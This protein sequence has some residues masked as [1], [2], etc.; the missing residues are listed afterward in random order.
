M[1]GKEKRLLWLRP[2]SIRNYYEL[3]KKNSSITFGMMELNFYHQIRNLLIGF[4]LLELSEVLDSANHLRSVRVFVVVPSNNL[5]ERV[6]VTHL[7]NHSLV[8]IEE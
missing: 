4:F 5:Y 2:L 8:S 1:Q 3:M 7:R 6:T